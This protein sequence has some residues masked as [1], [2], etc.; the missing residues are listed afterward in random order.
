MARSEGFRARHDPYVK[1][2]VF[3]LGLFP[4][5][6]YIGVFTGCLDQVFEDDCHRLCNQKFLSQKN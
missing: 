1:Y 2:K 6:G 5:Y 4:D 3:L